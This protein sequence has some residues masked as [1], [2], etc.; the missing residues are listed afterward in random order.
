ML[1]RLPLPRLLNRSLSLPLPLPLQLPLLPPLWLRPTSRLGSDYNPNRRPQL[2][3]GLELRDKEERG[4]ELRRG[5]SMSVLSGGLGGL[6]VTVRPADLAGYVGG[7]LAV[8]GV[9]ER[10]AGVE[11]LLL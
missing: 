9:Q 11:G 8:D 7:M 1:L 10:E 6:C 2:F 5:M 4:M 3:P